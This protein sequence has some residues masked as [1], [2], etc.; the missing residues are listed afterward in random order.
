M[1]RVRHA[2]MAVVLGTGAMGCA[3]TQSPSNVA[4]YSIWHCDEC[5]DF[6]TPAYGPGY[7]MMPGSYTVV[8]GQK[9]PESKPTTNSAL[10]SGAAPPPAQV[11]APPPTTTTPPTP[12]AA[13]APGLGVNMR[14]PVVRGL[15]LPNT[16]VTGAASDLPPLMSGVR[17]DLQVPVASR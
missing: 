15:G 10:D 2:V 1:V 9:S 13:A 16:V 8:P 7:S 4:H 11:P 5:D 14:Q 6:P 17:G 12:P 3:L